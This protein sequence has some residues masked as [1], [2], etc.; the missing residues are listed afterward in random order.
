LI[1]DLSSKL[2][3]E[4]IKVTRGA[5]E[6]IEKAGGSVADIIE[7]SIRPKGVKKN[8]RGIGIRYG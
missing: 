8:R 1:F 2:N 5:K 3:V 6:S 7:T 4:G